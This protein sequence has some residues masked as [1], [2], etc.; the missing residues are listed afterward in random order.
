M[1]LHLTKHPVWCVWNIQGNIF[2]LSLLLWSWTS[3]KV[4]EEL[5]ATDKRVCNNCSVSPHCLLFFII[6][7]ALLF[8]ALF[9]EMLKYAQWL[10]YFIFS[11]PR[12]VWFLNSNRFF[13]MLLRLNSESDTGFVLPC[14]C[15]TSW[16]C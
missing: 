6:H 14:I 16:V 5:Q 3:E 1:I 8:T 2:C 15:Q 7:W 12:N 9:N 11:I 10:I 13:C 4:F